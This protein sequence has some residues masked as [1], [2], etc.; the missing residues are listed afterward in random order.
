M[1]GARGISIRKKVLCCL[2]LIVIVGTLIP[3]YT[4]RELAECQSS[5]GRTNRGA[6]AETGSVRSP[7]DS[8]EWL[9]L[10]DRI[11]SRLIA[12]SLILASAALT[13]WVWIQRNIFYPLNDV[14]ASLRLITQGRLNTIH[15]TN[16]NDEIGQIGELLNDVAADFQEILLA[17]WTHASRSVDQAERLQAI[18]NANPPDAVTRE[19]N[20]S[21]DQLIRESKSFQKLMEGFEFY[22]VTVDKNRLVGPG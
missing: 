3:I 10:I 18:L 8:I 4:V 6:L 17:S 1:G 15:P 5:I 2:A 21:C 16:R 19:L 20:Q 13:M 12:F 14:T 11:Q 7:A 22:D 9:V